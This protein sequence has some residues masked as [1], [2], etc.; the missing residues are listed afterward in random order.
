MGNGHAV[1]DETIIP[2]TPAK[3]KGGRPLG[4][5]NKKPNPFAVAKE[6]VPAANSRLS[7]TEMQ[8]AVGEVPVPL[9]A[10]PP[11]RQEP[12]TLR[13]WRE[14][15]QL[16]APEEYP[17]DE[18]QD[19]RFHINKRE[20]PDGF[21]LQWVGVTIW[22]QPQPQI[23][24]EFLRKG[25]EPVCTGDFDGE[26]DG[27]FVPRSH[28]GPIILEGLMLCA[29]PM[30]WSEKAR[31]IARREASN[32]VKI[33]VDQLRKGELDAV[34]LDAQHKSALAFNHINVGVEGVTVPVPPKDL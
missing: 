29:R 17:A 9:R 7:N 26:F 23:E 30:A 33:K 8:P 13:P 4:S 14:R 32:Q 18:Q 15:H 19:Q 1:S 5:K 21:D 24:A 11:T 31:S 6:V 28:H 3:N 10:A 22:G 2:V 16:R 34:T 20:F 27:R 12:V 25:W